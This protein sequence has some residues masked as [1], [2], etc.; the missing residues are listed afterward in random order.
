MLRVLTFLFLASC[1][2]SYL[3]SNGESWFWSMKS[4]PSYLQVEWWRNKI[5]RTASPRPSAGI[6]LTALV[7]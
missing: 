6:Q 7:C 3:I 1:G 4:P 2:L 5:V